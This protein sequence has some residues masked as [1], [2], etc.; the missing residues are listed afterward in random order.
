MVLLRLSRQR[1]IRWVAAYPISGD[2]LFPRH[3][4]TGTSPEFQRIQ[5][6]ISAVL[7][8]KGAVYYNEGGG[9]EILICVKH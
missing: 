7:P 5:N 3:I 8:E 6:Y 2:D 9:E 1:E 4:K